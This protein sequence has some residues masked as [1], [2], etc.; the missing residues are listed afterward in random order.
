MLKQFD[1]IEKVVA[2]YANESIDTEKAYEHKYGGK[3]IQIDNVSVN[4]KKNAQL[5]VME[6]MT[7][8]INVASSKQIDQ[9]EFF[10]LIYNEDMYCV[11]GAFER[12]Q[13]R[14]SSLKEGEN[15]ISLSL[16][17]NLHPG[18][19][20]LSV[21]AFDNERNFIEWVQLCES[22]EVETYYT[23]GR[24]FHSRLGSIIPQVEWR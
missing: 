12:D 13:N 10:V 2:S 6:E 20:F 11:S 15:S 7:V 1:D 8:S 5:R 3:T 14:F 18:K 22:F 16:T 24:F 19:Y 4:G 23:D 9:V 17:A 21:G